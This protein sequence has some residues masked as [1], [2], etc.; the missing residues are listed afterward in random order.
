MSPDASFRA[1]RIW[2][3]VAE[4]RARVLHI[5]REDT[6][7]FASLGAIYTLADDALLAAINSHPDYAGWPRY[8]AAPAA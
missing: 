8:D 2:R 7:P 6:P 1:K 4:G 3:L 5:G